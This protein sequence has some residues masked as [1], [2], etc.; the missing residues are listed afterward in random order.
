MTGF[1]GS[2]GPIGFVGSQGYQGDAGLRGFDGSRGWTG[3]QGY[4]GW[5]GSRGLV[6]SVGSLGY[7]GSRGFTGSAGAGFVGSRGPT[8]WIGSQGPFGYTGSTGAGFVGSRGI[9]GEFGFTGSR[10]TGWTGSRGFFGF[11]GS[12]GDIGYTG[13]AGAGYTGS[14]G[15]IGPLGYTGSVGAM[16]PVGL[17]LRIIGHVDTP[18]ELPEEGD[19]VGDTY[20]VGDSDFAAWVESPS[21]QWL[22]WT[23][24]GTQG[25][26]GSVGAQGLPAVM[27]DVK[28]LLSNTGELPD[29]NTAGS[30]DAYIV[31]AD[32]WGI[33]DGDWENFGTFVGPAGDAGAVGYTGS[34]GASSPTI[35]VTGQLEDIGD[36]PAANSVAEHSA[37]VVGDELHFSAANSWV[38]AGPFRGYAGSLG[39]TGS[40]GASVLANTAYGGNG[41]IQFSDSGVLAGNSAFVYDKANNNVTLTSGRLNLMANS[42]T[43]LAIQQSGNVASRVIQFQNDGLMDGFT[44]GIRLRASG[45]GGTAGVVQFS[46][47]DTAAVTLDGFNSRVQGSADLKLWANTA[48]RLTLSGNTG[49]TSLTLGDAN[50]TLNSITSTGIISLESQATSGVRVARAAGSIPRLTVFYPDTTS[51]V[52]DVNGNT[53]LVS[54]AANVGLSFASSVATSNS[55][56]GRHLSLHGSGY[57]LNVTSGSLNIVVPGAANVSIVNGTD[58]S[59]A[60]SFNV[61]TGAIRAGSGSNTAPSIGFLGD[62]DVGLFLPS[63]NVLGFAAGGAEVARMQTAGVRIVNGTGVFRSTDGTAA[64]PAFTFDGDLNNGMYLRATDS[65]GFSC[66]SVLGFYLT[67]AGSPVF[68]EHAV[69]GTAATACMTTGGTLQRTTSSIRYKKDVEPMDMANSL[70]LIQ[71]AEP[72]WYRS[73]NAA[74]E[75]SWSWYGFIAEDIAQIDPRFAVWDYLKEDLI[76]GEPI[77]G[78]V[79]VPDNVDYARMVAP[80]I[81]VLKQALARIDTLEAQNVALEVRLTA[82]ES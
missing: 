61:A 31:G 8:G 27:R 67:N 14:V 76:E 7:T 45:S 66:N 13:S 70:N 32:L 65:I 53:E 10:G 81:H 6:G 38:N 42:G 79:K 21:P 4:Q 72:V 62:G 26:T 49:Y 33:I 64:A 3:S 37:Y 12:V 75:P 69:V 30:T 58:G 50:T 17:E 19:V 22:Q 5:T 60:F 68:P 28:G 34:R 56:L 25:Y 54:L 47:A 23:Y 9:P 63:S 71:N 39:Y 82:L 51:F 78:A 11:T 77:E 52:F 59:R 40:A 80:I 41:A 57:G 48:A 16:G 24:R 74:D 44:T 2:Q 29:A 20:T 1:T 15:A 55:D 46:G 36:L 35:T 73:K 18:E 43:M